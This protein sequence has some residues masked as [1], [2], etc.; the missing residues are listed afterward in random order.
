MDHYTD[1]PRLRYTRIYIC[2]YY[3]RPLNPRRGFV[4]TINNNIKLIFRSYLI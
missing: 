2:V 4:R 1:R 3:S